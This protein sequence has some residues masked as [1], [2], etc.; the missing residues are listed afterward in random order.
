MVKVC[1]VRNWLCWA[2]PSEAACALAQPRASLEQLAGPVWLELLLL[3]QNYRGTWR[4]LE[5]LYAPG[6]G[7]LAREVLTA[8]GAADVSLA[9]LQGQL[10]SVVAQV[11][12][13]LPVHLKP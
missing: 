10:P 4:V 2:E 13:L 9:E 1:H 8:R 6:G 7:A 11:A 12:H 5:Q 3:P